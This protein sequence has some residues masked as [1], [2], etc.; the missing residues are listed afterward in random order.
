VMEMLPRLRFSA[1]FRPD[2]F[3]LAITNPVGIFIENAR[4][5]RID[6][7]LP[8]WY[9][10]TLNEAQAFVLLPVKTNDSTIAL[11]YGD[12]TDP[13]NVR[14]ISAAEMS[15]LNDLTRELGRF[16]T[17]ANWKEVELI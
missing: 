8:R 12:W 14:K 3:H 10:E 16:F 5:A 15:S 7:R 4:D 6:A 13:Q 11:V 1:D 2:V 17:G 9:K